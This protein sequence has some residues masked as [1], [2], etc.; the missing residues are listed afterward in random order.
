MMALILST[1]CQMFFSTNF[2]YFFG[3]G[4]FFCTSHFFRDVFKCIFGGIYVFRSS[5]NFAICYSMSKIFFYILIKFDFRFH[6]LH[7]AIMSILCDLLIR[8]GC[9]FAA[10]KLHYILLIGIFHA[11][12]SYFN[13]TPTGRILSR[14]SKDL[15]VVDSIFPTLLTD[16]LECAFEVILYSNTPHHIIHTQF[17]KIH[18]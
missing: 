17:K 9:L 3:V 15:D 16:L 10:I 8:L 5:S 1:L 12:I 2:V 7:T 14:F 18:P 4:F 13:Q 11:P 6:L